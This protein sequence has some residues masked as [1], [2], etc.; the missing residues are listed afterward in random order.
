MKTIVSVAA[1]AAFASLVQAKEMAPNE[2]LGKSLY[3]SGVRHMEIMNHKEV[4]RI[5]RKHPE[6]V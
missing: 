5:P 3:D 2:E 1:V 6:Y 4:N